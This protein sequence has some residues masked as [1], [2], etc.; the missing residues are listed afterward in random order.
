MN[1]H[2]A[3]RSVGNDAVERRSVVSELNF[4]RQ[5]TPWRVAWR[6]FSNMMLGSTLWLAPSERAAAPR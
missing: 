3:I 4:A 5:E 6:R 1:P 2:A